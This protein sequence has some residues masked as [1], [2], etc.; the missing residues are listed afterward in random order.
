MTFVSQQCVCHCLVT[1]D[2]DSLCTAVGKKKKIQMTKEEK[3][4]SVMV[5][6][7]LNG[8]TGMRV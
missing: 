2:T 7:E 6:L 3:S 1:I 8:I 4:A 5:A